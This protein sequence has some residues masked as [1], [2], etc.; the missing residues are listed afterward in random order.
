MDYTLDISRMYLISSKLR[1][2]YYERTKAEVKELG[3]QEVSEEKPEEV[4]F[5][6]DTV[7][8]FFL[9]SIS[10]AYRSIP[11]KVFHTSSSERC[12]LFLFVFSVMPI[13]NG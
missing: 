10:Y 1:S 3:C 5:F 6:T 4:C 12:V 11:L 7:S 2:L 13:A 8:V 9:F